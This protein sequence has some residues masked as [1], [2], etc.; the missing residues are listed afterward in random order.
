MTEDRPL[1]AEQTSTLAADW[2]SRVRSG[3]LSDI[4]EVALETWL[5]RDPANQSAY[6]AVERTWNALELVRLHPRVLAMRD[7]LPTRRPFSLSRYLPPKAIAASVA[8]FL[9]GALAFGV[10]NPS[11]QPEPARAGRFESQVYHTS[12]GQRAVISLPDGS[13]VLLSEN[14]SLRTIAD[15]GRRAL[16][17][18]RGRAFFRVAKD[19]AHPFVVQADGR[20][21]TAVG[22][23]FEVR[24]DNGAFAVTLVEGRVRVQTPVTAAAGP[25]GGRALGPA[26]ASIETTEMVAGS[27]L[28]AGPEGWSVSRDNVDESTRWTR[29]QLVFEAQPLVEVTAQMNLRS[30][31]KIVILDDA[32]GRTLISGNF[33]PGDVDGFANALAAYDYASVG[34]RADGSIEISRP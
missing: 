34:T 14:A 21:I 20:T 11:T 7:G 24:V 13:E 6:D 12:A 19:T 16:R 29:D 27:R 33:R 8:V 1:P 22:T 26:P 9:A 28:A 30:P 4:D 3:C 23:A 15:P 31:R 5:G 17:L 18:E 10:L 32:V 2:F 25:S